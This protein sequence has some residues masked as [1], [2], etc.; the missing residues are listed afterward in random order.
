MVILP[1]RARQ[2]IAS[3]LVNGQIVGDWVVHAG[4]QG[5]EVKWMAEQERCQV[6]L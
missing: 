3:H 4:R 2:I 1:D 6:L 5:E